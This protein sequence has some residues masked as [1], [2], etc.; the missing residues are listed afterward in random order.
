MADS[1]VD[2]G[3]QI[4]LDEG[5][6][7]IVNG[8][9]SDDIRGLCSQLQMEFMCKNKLYFN[10]TYM[11]YFTYN[12]IDWVPVSVSEIMA[13]DGNWTYN[14]IAYP[15]SIYK[16]IYQPCLDTATLASALGLLLSPTSE[17]LK[18]K[19]PVIN[20][21]SG[22]LIK[23]VRR[24]SFNNAALSGDLGN[25]YFIYID[26]KYLHS[27]TWKKLIASNALDLTVPTEIVQGTDIVKHV[28]DEI[29]T[30][31]KIT[32]HPK[33]WHEEDFLYRIMKDKFDIFS[34]YPTYFANMYTMKFGNTSVF[35]QTQKFL[36]IRSSFEFTKANGY[37]NTFARISLE[38]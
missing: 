35:D 34:T 2:S 37:T 25:A 17:I 20:M 7:R 38:G 32:Q 24:Q 28:Q 21:Y 12:N 33:V 16:P 11:T 30:D 18:I 6:G 1:I 5:E 27:I 8:V 26:S 36:C 15:K 22:Y 9:W 31:F 29:I 3:R 10:D 13:S 4:N 19:C 14:V 23:E